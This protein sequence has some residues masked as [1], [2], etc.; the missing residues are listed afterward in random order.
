[1]EYHT[2]LGVE[3]LV[4]PTSLLSLGGCTEFPSCAFGCICMLHACGNKYATYDFK[5]KYKTSPKDSIGCNHIIG[6]LIY[7]QK[8]TP[9]VPFIV[10]P[11]S[12]FSF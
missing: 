6:I 5:L 11:Y 7:S 8:Y 1:M 4:Y 12:A 9:Y 2:L 3:S 10:D